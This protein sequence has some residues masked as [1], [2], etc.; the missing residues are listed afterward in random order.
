MCVNCKLQYIH[1]LLLMMKQYVKFVGMMLEVV[2]R[3][4]IWKRNKKGV[5]GFLLWLGYGFGLICNLFSI[6]DSYKVV[7]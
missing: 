4:L 2:E 7:F 3:V 5:I 6:V 1:L